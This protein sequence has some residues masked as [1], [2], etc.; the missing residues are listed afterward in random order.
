MAWHRLDHRILKLAA[1]FFTD[2]FNGMNWPITV[3][4]FEID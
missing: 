1:P 3:G 4:Q 2:R